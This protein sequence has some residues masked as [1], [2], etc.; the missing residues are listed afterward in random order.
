MVPEP[1]V[2]GSYDPEKSYSQELGT[3]PWRGKYRGPV[4]SIF[5]DL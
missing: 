2:P 4:R 5:R 1:V 3:A